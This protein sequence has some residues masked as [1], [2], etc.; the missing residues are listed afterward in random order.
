MTTDTSTLKEVGDEVAR[1]LSSS[2]TRADGT[3]IRTPLLFPSGSHAVALITA[4]SANTFLVT[5]FGLAFEEA[6]LMGASSTF[7]HQATK[8][9]KRYGLQFDSR[10]F[11]L[12]EVPR[13]LL[14]SA[15]TTVANVAVKTVEAA[16]LKHAERR[17]EEEAARMVDRLRTIFSPKSVI[18]QAEV[19]GASSHSWRVDAAVKS[20]H[21]LAA[22]DFV[23]PHHNSIVSTVAKFSDIARLDEDAPQ[24]ISMVQSKT[25]LQ[26]Y[27]DV[28]SSVSDVVDERLPDTKLRE[29]AEAA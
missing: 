20:G 24:R 4:S 21:R 3:Y 12:F 1:Q 11:F 13:D 25:S 17:E 14:V 28:L 5:D 27:L 7:T 26:S 9:A 6:D 15:V 16:A 2:F 10:S 22:F 8:Y 19:R 23:K 18:E 29:L